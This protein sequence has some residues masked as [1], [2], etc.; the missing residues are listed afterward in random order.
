MRIEI[1]YQINGR[2]IMKN[3]KKMFTEKNR[4]IYTI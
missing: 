1:K 3:I 2:Y 4:K